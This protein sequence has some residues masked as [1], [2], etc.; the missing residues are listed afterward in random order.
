MSRGPSIRAFITGLGV[1]TPAGVGLD[2]QVR[3]LL[4]SSVEHRPLE[5]LWLFEPGVGGPRPAG[6]VPRELPLPGPADWPRTHRLAL[7][8]A[9]QAMAGA[10]LPPDAV[11]LGVTT[12]GMPLSEELL[13]AGVKDPQRYR[14]H[15]S[16]TVAERVARA[17]GCRGPALTVS[18]A[19]SSAGVA[20]KV[21]LEL[22][23]AGRCQRV[24]AGGADALCRLTYFGFSLLKLVDPRGTRPLDRE[25]AGMSV[26][27]GAAMLLLHAAETPHPGVIAE[28]LGGGLS[29]DAHHPTAPHP[30]GLGAFL[31]MQ[32]ALS[33][34]GLGPRRI[35]YVNLHGTGTRDN[36]AAEALAV[37]DLFD[38]RLPPVSSTKGVFGHPLAAAGAVEAV[39]CLA[40]L[41]RDLLPANV[42]LTEPDPELGLTPLREPRRAELHAV[43]SNSFGFG[44][45]NAALVLGAVRNTAG[46]AVHLSGPGGRLKAPPGPTACLRVVGSACLTGAGHTRET[47]ERFAGGQRCAG[48]LPDADVVRELPPRVCRRQKRLPRLVLALGQALCPDAEAGPR[49]IF[50]GTG[51]GPLSETHDFLHELF[52]DPQR[53]ASPIDFV[54]SVHNAPAGQL[55]MRLGARGANLTASVGD[56]SFEAALLMAELLALDVEERETPRARELLVLG[57][58]EHHP[59]LSPLFDPCG[60]E[61][62]DGGG[63]LWLRPEADCAPGQA[64]PSVRLRACRLA[65]ERPEDVAAGLAALVAELGGPAALG[66]RYGAL[67]VDLPAGHRQGGERWRAFVQAAAFPGPVVDVRPL[68]GEFA[69]ASAVAAV[70]AARLVAGGELPAG[71]GAGRGPVALGGRGVLLVGLGAHLTAVDF[72]P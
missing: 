15:G 47:W 13:L 56:S 9:E 12:G 38:D 43:M 22:I 32:A 53:L 24:L 50:F 8:A 67:L 68:L 2:A 69:S 72:S 36:D 10:E 52:S 44:G 46:Q 71:L 7:A 58:D 54:G 70:L 25:R 30:E 19:C 64:G 62:A 63:A 31:A 18:T 60:G 42:G 35:D 6:Q 37:R 28:L 17:V 51:F 33:D 65:P 4:E 34:A 14:L 40:A 55:A 45:N 61:P 3:A 49:R 26:S 16:G 1:V 23:R 5:P 57:A 20:L 39:V 41:T 29:C 27:E 59:V 66:E 21:A 11:V 48:L